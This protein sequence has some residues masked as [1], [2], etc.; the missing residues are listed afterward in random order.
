M[1][2][3]RDQQLR[4]TLQ[5]HQGIPNMLAQF[6]NIAGCHV[7]QPTILGPAPDTLVGIGVW[8]VC[9]EALYYYFGVLAKPCLDHPCPSV[10][11][12]S[13]PHDRPRA[14]DLA[15]ELPQEQHDLLAVE[16]FVVSQQHEVQADTRGPR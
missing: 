10:D 16:V 6:G 3:E 12:I 8:S 15:L 2:D 14:T 1:K 13:V 4:L 7:T 11:L 9:R 5:G